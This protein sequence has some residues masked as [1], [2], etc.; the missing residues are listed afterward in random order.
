LS[1][2]NFG[3]FPGGGT[4]WATAHNLPRKQALYYALTGA[5]FTGREA[6]ALGLATRAV[7][8]KDLPAATDA[9]VNQVVNKNLHT[10]RATKEVYERVL[11]L[12]FPA[13]IDWEMAK[14]HELSY[15]SRD[16]WIRDAL[17]QFRRRE[18]RPGLEAYRLPEGE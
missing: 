14:L 16:A 13:G 15:R 12:D 1:E 10:L 7:P 3:I 17:T 5:T 6:V 11:W 18:Y 4:M 8:L 2:I 9:I